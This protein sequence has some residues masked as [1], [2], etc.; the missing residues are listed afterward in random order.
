MFTSYA[1]VL[2]TCHVLLH[3][4]NVCAYN[5]RL[6]N[7]ISLRPTWTLMY[8]G[9]WVMIWLTWLNL[10][11]P[12][13][14]PW[15]RLRFVRSHHAFRSPTSRTSCAIDMVIQPLVSSSHWRLGRPI[16]LVP[17]LI[18]SMTVFFIFTFLLFFYTRLYLDVKGRNLDTEKLFCL[19][20][21]LQVLSLEV[22]T[23][24]DSYA[25]NYRELATL[26]TLSEGLAKQCILNPASVKQILRHSLSNGAE[27][28]QPLSQTWN[29]MSPIRISI[30]SS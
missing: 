15:C 24:R 19:S 18:P 14:A 27:R 13:L 29:S 22:T 23:P 9:L 30:T 3:L 25:W 10:R 1:Y 6:L 11:E 5:L 21:S 16:Y 4:L 26:L 17:S 12:G 20:S 2:D 7:E 8:C 28:R